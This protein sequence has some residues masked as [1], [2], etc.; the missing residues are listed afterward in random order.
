MD[1]RRLG[2]LPNEIDAAFGLPRGRVARL[3]RQG[4]GPETVEI[5]GV[6]VVLNSALARWLATLTEHAPALY[7]VSDKRQDGRDREVLTAR[8]PQAALNAAAALL[9]AGDVGVRV[10]VVPTVDPLLADRT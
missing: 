9:D 8:D 6:P 4:R 1:H 7:K 10:E 2:F 5:D 3:T